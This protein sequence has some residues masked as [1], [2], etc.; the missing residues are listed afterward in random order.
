MKLLFAQNLSHRLPTLL[1]AEFPQA[2]HV[3]DVDMASAE[4]QTVWEYARR[5]ARLIVSKDSDFEQRSLLYGHPPKVIWLRLGNCPTIAIVALLRSRQ[6]DI[7]AFY[8]D[9]EASILVLS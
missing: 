9:Q 4:D 6:E 5:H 2:Q 8:R 7:A 1:A 3:R